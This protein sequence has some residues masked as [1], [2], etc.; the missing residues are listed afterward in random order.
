LL[1]I[2]SPAILNNLTKEALLDFSVFLYG[3][4]TKINTNN[5]TNFIPFFPTK[6]IKYALS[7]IKIIL[8]GFMRH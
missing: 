8:V 3:A 2:L 5:N 1:I 4:L 6:I 7:L